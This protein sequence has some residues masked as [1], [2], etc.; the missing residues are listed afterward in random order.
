MEILK[1]CLLIL[2]ALTALVLII[3]YL[4]PVL[5]KVLGILAYVVA[6]ALIVALILGLIWYIANKLR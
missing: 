2:G 4:L 5:L 3:K 1:K 6:C